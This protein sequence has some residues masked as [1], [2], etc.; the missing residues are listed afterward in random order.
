[1]GKHGITIA[2]LIAL[3]AGGLLLVDSPPPIL[4]TP[5]VVVEEEREAFPITVLENV[6]TTQ[7]S[8]NGNVE[9]HFTAKRVAQF[10]EN[11]KEPSES[12]YANVSQ[13]LFIFF[14]N[15]QPGWYLQSKTGRSSADGSEVILR[16]K[17]EAWQVNKDR[18]QVEIHTEEMLLKPQQQF[19]S[20]DKPVMIDA[21]TSHYRGN[22]GMEAD[23]K[24]ERFKLYDGTG[25]YE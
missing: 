25:T 10:Q 1:M 19:A 14:E 3:T 11:L 20:T 13:P 2:I 9:Y 6:A 22:K 17:V 24:Q 7:Y 4:L 21:P 18:T 23:L 16:E 15:T 8:A 5:P 12:D